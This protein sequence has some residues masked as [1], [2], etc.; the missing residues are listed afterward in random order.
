MQKQS[1]YRREGRQVISQK[2][3]KTVA[4]ITDDGSPVMQ[5][6]FRSQ[7]TAVA[8]FLDSAGA[9]EISAGNL[10]AR[11]RDDNGKTPRTDPPEKKGLE[12]TPVSLVHGILH[13]SSARTV[14][15]ILLFL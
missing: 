4:L 1:P 10:P 14:P 7:G 5:P 6:G 12:T 2:T 9:R 11:D 8:A 15:E 3:G 13:S